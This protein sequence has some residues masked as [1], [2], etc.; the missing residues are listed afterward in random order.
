LIFSNDTENIVIVP[1]QKQI[2]IIKT[3]ADDPLQ[4]PEKPKAPEEDDS[5]ADNNNMKTLELEKTL[6]NIGNLLQMAYG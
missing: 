3:L 2:G 6:Y 5:K 1:I 4:K